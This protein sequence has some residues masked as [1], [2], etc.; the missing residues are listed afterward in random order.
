MT[1]PTLALFNQ[2]GDLVSWNEHWQQNPEQAAK[3]AHSGL[4]P[5][6]P[7]EPAMALNLCSGSYTAVVR[8]ENN[9]SGVALLD[10]YSMP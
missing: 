6:Y 8:D 4:A 5:R 3:I 7:N 9:A 2:Q 1:N 10:I